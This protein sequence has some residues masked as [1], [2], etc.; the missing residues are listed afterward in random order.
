[1]ALL[2]LQESHG[3]HRAKESTLETSRSI[4]STATGKRTAAALVIR[5]LEACRVG[6]ADQALRFRSFAHGRRQ[7]WD[8]G[9]QLVPRRQQPPTFRP[10]L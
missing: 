8:C 10:R 5:D 2:L 7:I 6:S 1:M 4:G 3:E 9:P